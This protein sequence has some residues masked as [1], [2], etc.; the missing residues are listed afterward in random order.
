[1]SSSGS[2]LRE[3]TVRIKRPDFLLF[4][5]LAVGLVVWFFLSLPAPLRDAE[6]ITNTAILLGLLAF[7]LVFDFRPQ[8]ASPDEPTGLSLNWAAIGFIVA[9]LS[10]VL[11]PGVGKVFLLFGSICCFL[12]AAGGVLLHPSAKR[13][14]NSLFIAFTIFGA[15]LVALPFL[16]Y[17]LRILAGQWSA[18]AFDWIRQSTE[19]FFVVQDGVPML[20]LVVNERPFHVAAECNGFGLLGTSLILTF[21]FWFY[22]KV[23]VLDGFLL[24]IAAVFLAL[25]GNLVRIFVIV[26]LAPLVGDHYMLMHEIVGTVAFY[27]FLAI[28]WWLIAGFGRSPR[29]ARVETPNA[30]GVA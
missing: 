2:A 14:I 5:G 11:A 16:D 24:L 30:E 22:R 19:L 3:A 1:M 28:Q 13:L 9:A 8:I 23:S 4:F 25:V 21:A 26:S 27:G 18:K 6:Q 12:R 29:Q 17:P 7:Y 10:F 20:L 15:L